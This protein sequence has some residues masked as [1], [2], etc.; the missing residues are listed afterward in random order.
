LAKPVPPA[1]R[2]LGVW[3]FDRLVDGQKPFERY[4]VVR[5]PAPVIDLSDGSAALLAELRGRSSRVAGGLPRVQRRLERDFGALRFEFQTTDLAALRTLMEWKSA[6]YRRTG[7]TDRFA[8]AWIRHFVSNLVELRSPHFTLVLSVL[9]AGDE[10][11]AA[12]LD[13]RREDVMAGWFTAYDP[14]FAKYSPGMLHRLHLIEAAAASGVRLL[15]MGR[16]TYDHK[17]LFKTRDVM[18]GE[19]KVVR[20]S[21]G[22]ALYYTGRA[23]L[24]RLR[25]TVMDSPPLYRAADAVLRRYGHLHS[26]LNVHTPGRPQADALCATDGCG[27]RSP[28]HNEERS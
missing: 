13:L 19:G 27:P 22:A 12:N 18:V 23:P 5:A 11:V 15:E 16:G 10:P 8:R 7:R 1:V 2:Q 9:Y 21:A 25:Q 6:Q 26:T 17:E 14:R 4:Q 28:S 24:R 20:P 3:E